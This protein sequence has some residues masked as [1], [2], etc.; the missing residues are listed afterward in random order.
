MAL[1]I[2]LLTISTI[3]FLVATFMHNFA[4]GV[5]WSLLLHVVH[6]MVFGS[7]YIL[8]TSQ[9]FVNYFWSTLVFGVAGWILAMLLRIPAFLNGAY[10]ASVF[11]DDSAVRQRVKK[12][13]DKD[14]TTLKEE[15]EWMIFGKF[16]I[17]LLLVGIG[18]I[19]YELNVDGFPK[20]AGGIVLVVLDIIAWIAFYF[21]FR[22]ADGEVTL[23]FNSPDPRAEVATISF[24]M[25]AATIIYALTYIIFQSIDCLHFASNAPNVYT[26]GECSIFYGDQWYFYAS[27][28]AGGFVIVWSV[29]VGFCSGGV[30]TPYG[31]TNQEYKPL[32]HQA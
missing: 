18:H 19:I 28:I 20:W 24:N 23:L 2:S 32:R 15:S 14:G 5:T 27:L 30:G 29:V 21:L 9:I 6:Y 22:P 4:Y 10:Y 31:S 8:P 12:Q 26:D 25:A 16:L 11:S 13:N 1:A 17:P 3:S 7:G